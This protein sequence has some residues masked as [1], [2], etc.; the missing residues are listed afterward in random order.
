MGAQKA[1]AAEVIRGGADS[2]LALKGNQETMHRAVITCFAKYR[3]PQIRNGI[4]RSLPAGYDL[5][6][7]TSEDRTAGRSP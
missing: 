6:G 3:S 4:R 1:I 7:F 2:V 5:V